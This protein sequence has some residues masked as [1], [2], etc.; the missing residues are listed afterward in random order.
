MFN[1]FRRKNKYDYSPAIAKRLIDIINQV[2]KNISHD[3][4]MTYCY[5]NSPSDLI[6]VL[7]NYI[8]EIQRGNIKV[9][10][11]LSVEFAATSSLQEHSLGNGW[12]DEYLIIAEEFDKIKRLVKI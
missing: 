4:D 6:A 5:Y 3:S 10:D 2:K 9:I 12:S 11:D 8:Q 1:L 7:D